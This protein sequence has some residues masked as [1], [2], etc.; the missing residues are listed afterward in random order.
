MTEQRGR[1]RPKGKKSNPEYI[2][3][4]TYIKVKTYKE[5]KKRCVDLDM[6]MSEVVQELLEDWLNSD[7]Q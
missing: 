5:L 4:T 6:E 7:H 2:T 3:L 1:G